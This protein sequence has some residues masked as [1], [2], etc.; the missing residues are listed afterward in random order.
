MSCGPRLCTIVSVAV[1]G[2]LITV[3][4]VLPAAEILFEENWESGQI[5]PAR[6]RAQSAPETVLAVEDISGDGSDHALAMWIGPKMLHWS[7][8]VRGVRRFSRS[9][10]PVLSALL[11]GDPSRA[12]EGFSYPL[13]MAWL[14]GFHNERELKFGHIYEDQEAVLDNWFAPRY[15]DN[16][17]RLQFTQCPVKSM[18]QQGSGGTRLSRGFS[19][20]LKTAVSKQTAIRLR[21]HLGVKQGAKFEWFNPLTRAWVEEANTLGVAGG[22]TDQVTLGFGPAAACVLIDDIVV[23]KGPVPPPRPATPTP[24]GVTLFE[25]WE[26]GRIDPDKWRTRRGGSNTLLSVVDVSGDGSDHALAMWIGPGQEDWSLAVKS[27]LGLK[28]SSSPRMTALI[29][30][31]PTRTGPRHTYPDG[32]GWLLGFHHDPTIEPPIYKDLEAGLDDW[33]ARDHG[34]TKLR[35]TQAPR[36]SPFAQGPGGEHL[37]ERLVAAL[38][39][40]TS[41]DK[42]VAIRLTLGP[43]QGAKFEWHEPAKDEWI[44]EFDTIGVSG[45]TTE[46]VGIGFG[47]VAACVFIDDITVTGEVSEDYDGLPKDFPRFRFPGHDRRAKLL[48]DFYRYHFANRIVPGGYGMTLFNKEYVTISDTWAAGAVEGPRSKPI[49]ESLRESLLGIRQDEDGYIH[50]H[51]HYSHAHESGWPFP[52]WTQVPGGPL[53]TTIGWHFN[54]RDRGWATADLQRM[55]MTQHLGPAAT[56][57]WKLENAESQG[58]V[59]GK[60][61]LRATGPS[62]LLTPPLDAGIDA[63]NCPFLQLRW[64]RSPQ[65]PEAQSPY[66]EWMRREDSDFSPQRR[67]SFGYGQGGNPGYEMVTGTKHSMIQMHAHPMWNGQIKALRLSLAPGESDLQFKIDSFFTV[68]DTRHSMNNPIFILANWNYFRWTGDVAFLR[69]NIGRIRK[70]LGYQRRVMGGAEHDFI[71]NPWPGHDGRP[72]FD[73]GPPKVFHHGHGIGNYYCDILPFGGDDAAA[74]AQYY[75]STLVMAQ[76]EEAVRKHPEWNIPASASA[77][78][79]AELRDHAKQVQRTAGRKFWNPQTGRFVACVD[80]DGVPRDYG[81]TI[82]NQEA[83]WYGLADDTHARSIMDWISGK[84]MV[85]GDTS[86]G[87]DIYWWR[88]AP[89]IS[90]KRNIEWYA[91]IWRSPESIPW[92]D[93][94]QDGGAVLGF[95]FYDLWARLQVY[96]P[97]D[98]W[99]RLEEILDWEEDVWKVGGYRNYYAN[100]AGTM[101]GGGPPGGIGIDQEFLETSM[102]PAIVPLGFLGLDPRA[103]ALAIHPRLPS[104]CPEMTVTNILYHR[105]KMNVTAR[106]DRLEIELLEAPFEPIRVQLPPGWQSADVSPGPD[107]VS[108][109]AERKYRFQRSSQ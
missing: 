64:L 88:C 65:L 85:Q 97:D 25:D 86:T 36:P 108:L 33:L 34:A 22:E 99:R 49:Q 57:G 27:K 72:G 103:D 58:V 5:D 30:G 80:A 83:I 39:N 76:A 21:I 61:I 51:Q 4:D 47:P 8:S 20:A 60:W 7:I 1:T 42:A 81:Y 38:R 32:M 31:D 10:R 93:Q 100:H 62:P 91:F 109:S 96:G 106:N 53:G 3:A 41:K 95:S 69:R 79:P 89:R 17:T 48:T 24:P 67:V 66:V 29:W 16:N 87:A 45:G 70:A 84:R 54:D 6:W 26:S 13:G 11:W 94:I 90:T 98:A 71:R 59:D 82:N 101:Q 40:A 105:T 14:F 77:F 12:A 43:T 35:F 63:F 19:A 75:A 56:T 73:P 9:D 44:E 104:Q 37:S 107:G 78:D 15:G 102:L 55:K 46:E 2:I 50:V 74:T 68:Y 18:F 28:R 52:L 92:G 23:E